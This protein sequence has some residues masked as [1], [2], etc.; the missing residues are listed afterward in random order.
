[1]KRLLTGL[2]LIAVLAGTAAA[3]VAKPERVL[4]VEWQAGG[5]KLRW[6]SP[7]TMRPV[8]SAVLNVGGAPAHILATSPDGALAAIGGGENGRVRF[9]RPDGLRPAGLM[10]VGGASAFKGIWSAPDRLVV[11]V[12]GATAEVV[13]VDPAA[14]RVLQRQPLPGLALGVVRVGSRLLTVLAPRGRVGTAQLAVVEADGT[15][16]TVALGGIVAGFA[17]PAA[18]GAAGRQASP[19]LAAN[20]SRAVVVGVDRLAEIQLETLAVTVRPIVNRT[21]QKAAKLVHGWQRSAVWLRGDTVAFWGSMLGPDGP[22]S[23]GV[24]LLNV[25]TGTE[26]MLDA[27][28]LEAARAGSTLL[29]YGRDELGGYRLDATKRFTILQGTDTGYVQTAGGWAYVGSGNSTRFAVV[30][31]AGG[32]VVG[33]IRTA[34]PTTI[35]VP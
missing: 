32:R 10:W 27:F 6:V 17:P 8:G 25:A 12:G 20:G 34:K 22:S 31:V 35:L 13:V 16:R 19:A 9:M 2:L 29:T 15:V 28:A 1:M 30:D 33:H 5:G 14:R 18:A 7:T 4:A 24:R 23:I 11:L 26:R 21:T 3:G